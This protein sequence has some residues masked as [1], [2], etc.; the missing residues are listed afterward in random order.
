MNKKRFYLLVVA[1]LLI[2]N[3]FLLVM[4][5]MGPKGPHHHEGPKMLIV[6]KLHFDQQQIVAYEK[7]IS[8]HRASIRKH[9]NLLNKAKENLYSQLNTSSPENDS[10]YAVIAR[11][12]QKIE[13]IHFDH[14]EDIKSLCTKE[15]M[16]DFKKLTRE[17]ADLFEKRPPK[18]K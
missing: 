15:Q 14:F 3:G 8:Q 2:S 11:E 17:L 12:H 6:E 5:I 13:E 10:L 7:L 18:K 16:P 4:F 9:E 1:I